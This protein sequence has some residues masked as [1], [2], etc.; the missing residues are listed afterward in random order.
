MKVLII[1]SVCGIVSTGRI[2]TD[3]AEVLEKA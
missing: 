1:N 3:L 2:S